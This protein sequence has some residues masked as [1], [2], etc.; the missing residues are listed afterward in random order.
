MFSYYYKRYCYYSNHRNE[1]YYYEVTNQNIAAIRTQFNNSSDTP[2]HRYAKYRLDDFIKMGSTTTTNK[3]DDDM[4][5]NDTT[6]ERKYYHVVDGKEVAVEEVIFTVDF[7][8]VQNGQ[9]DGTHYLFMEIG[10]DVTRS[11]N[12]NTTVIMGPSGIPES[13]MKYDIYG[14]VTSEIVTTGGFVVDGQTQLADDI[15]IYKNELVTV[16]L[17]TDLNSST[18]VDGD[19]KEVADTKYGDYKLGAKIT[20][21][22]ESNSGY[23]DVTTDLFGTVATINNAQS[24][25][26]LDG[27]IRLQLAGRITNV[28]SNIML[29]FANSGLTAGNYKLVVETFASYD[30]EYYGDFSPTRNE[31]TFTLMSNEFG[32]DVSV[33]PIEVTHDVN[34][35]KDEAGNLTINYTLSTQS[36]LTNPNVKVYLERRKYSSAY[37]TEYEMVSLGGIA[38]SLT[39]NGGNNV[40]NS[41][42][43]PVAPGNPDCGIYNLTDQLTRNPNTVDTFDVVLTLRDGPTEQELSNKQDS[44]WKSG[45]YRLEFVIYDGNTP[46]GRVYE[47]LI[48][49]NLDLNE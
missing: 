49:R 14:N 35:G 40:L 5:G 28:E 15:S 26:Q 17:N 30:G 43:G 34:T 33:E 29:D 24:Y 42:F 44:K 7:S 18:M 9:V 19:R 13:D 2:D 8:E 39:V 1:Q 3:Y 46:I 47:Y 10:R 32:I 4:H 36:G 6:H 37:D 38:T 27:S 23:N 45:T 20:I 11:G 21:L 22:Q 12:T 16:R 31:Y 48:I 25:P 41:C